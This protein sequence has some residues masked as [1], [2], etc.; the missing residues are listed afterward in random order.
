MI[1]KE[2]EKLKKELNWL[3]GAVYEHTGQEVGAQSTDLENLVYLNIKL[4]DAIR[5]MNIKLEL[6]ISQF[7]AHE[8]NPFV[9]PKKIT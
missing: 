4:I 3:H 8:R 6:I 1:T 2:L 5:S 9:H 7:V